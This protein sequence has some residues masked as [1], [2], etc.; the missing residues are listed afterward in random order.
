MR[1]DINELHEENVIKK[2][3]WRRELSQ[4]KSYCYGY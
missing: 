2:S 1:R 3:S 4:A